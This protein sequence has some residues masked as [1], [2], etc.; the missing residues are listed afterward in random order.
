MST[1]KNFHRLQTVR[2]TNC[3]VST[4]FSPHPERGPETPMGQV[5]HKGIWVKAGERDAEFLGVRSSEYTVV[6]N[7]D[8]FQA[9]EDAS[10]DLGLDLEVHRASYYKKGRTQV[11]F[12]LPGSSY[13][14]KGDK[15]PII[16]G[17]SAGNHYNGGSSVTFP[18]FQL[19][20]VCTNGMVAKTYDLVDVVEKQIHIG[21]I[22]YND[23]YEMV[24]RTLQN[25]GRAVE[26]NML[27]ANL[28]IAT[29]MTD[30]DLNKWLDVIE[31]SAGK[32]KGEAARRVLTDSVETLG[33]NVWAVAQGISEVY[34]HE[35]K[36]SRSRED[37]RDREIN[38]LLEEM[39]VLQ[40][41]RVTI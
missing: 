3:L 14:I 30:E 10:Y 39:G 7:R 8:L 28:S 26:V 25:V 9:V 33:P 17:F 27:I 38:N 40:E 12:L 16:P 22:E 29:S 35:M 2:S 24:A 41:V 5:E 18:P 31:K 34:E 37:W 19:R 36:H 6:N 21:I 32:R 23:I 11:D 20:E 15:S 4:V 1:I 13:K